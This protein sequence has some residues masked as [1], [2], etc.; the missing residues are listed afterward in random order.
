[1]LESEKFYDN[2]KRRYPLPFSIVLSLSLSGSAF[3]PVNNIKDS[4]HNEPSAPLSN[5][6][7]I[8]NDTQNTPGISFEYNK[9]EQLNIPARS[10]RIVDSFNPISE[11]TIKREIVP[12][13]VNVKEQSNN[14][15]WV[16]NDN[17]ML[18]KICVEDLNALFDA[19]HQENI[20][21]YVKSGFR[22]I[23]QQKI[24]YSQ[25]TN[26]NT[27]VFPGVSQHHTGL[28]L[29][30]TTP[31]INNVIDVNANFSNTKAG[32]WLLEHAWEYG[33]VLS[34]T[35]NHDGIANE[36]WHYFY[37]GKDLASVWQEYQIN[38]RQDIDLFALQE[39]YS[40]Y[41]NEENKPFWEPP[42]QF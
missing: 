40:N 12:N 26:K 39:M 22:S 38:G 3:K 11:D 17:I 41:N 28:A 25:A 35:N 20:S 7:P 29:D 21:L 16:L 32:S 1:M 37:I 10:L 42:E 13:L 23:E 9:T 15:I 4:N 34:Y 33:F 2:R 30:F 8:S 27:V 5:P 19:I 6:I 14:N 24:A 31:E 18:D 36:D